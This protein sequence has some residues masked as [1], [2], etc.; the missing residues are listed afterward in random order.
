[1]LVTGGGCSPRPV[2]GACRAR[3][4]H[5]GGVRSRRRDPPES[6]SAEPLVRLAQA[7]IITKRLHPSWDLTAPTEFIGSRSSSTA[8]SAMNGHAMGLDDPAQ[9]PGAAVLVSGPMLY[10]KPQITGANCAKVSF[11]KRWTSP[12]PLCGTYTTSYG[13]SRMSAS[14]P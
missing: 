2:R 4:A 8:G 3:R 10:E 1:V 14:G 7:V 12:I 6:G 5:G 11:K 9:R 13:A